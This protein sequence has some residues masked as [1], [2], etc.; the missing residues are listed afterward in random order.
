MKPSANQSTPQSIAIGVGA[1]LIAGLTFSLSFAL[2]K[3]L[4]PEIPTAQI[5][6][7]RMSVGLLLLM[8]L[9]LR[10]PPG[11]L[12]TTRPGAHL[13]R[14]A[15]GATSMAMVYWAVPR[16]PLADLA[17]TQFV[18]PLFLTL[19]SAPLLG[20]M[21][22]WRRATATVVGFSG[23]I[24]MLKPTGAGFATLEPA[25]LVA[26]GSAF[27]YALAAIAMRQLGRTEPAL[28]TTIYFSAVAAMAGAI[29]CLFDWVDPTPRQWLLLISMGLVGGCGQYALVTAYARAPATIVAPF[30]YTQLIWAAVLGYVFWAEAPE[31]RGY[32]GAAI[33][34]GAGMYI[35]HREAIRQRVASPPRPLP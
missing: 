1:A 13:K 34:A 31:T 4:G 26:L 7:F 15:V 17:A 23:V 22:G 24:V 21:V 2:I 20:E 18:M 32:L 14:I 29:G 35:F 27:F 5:M 16:M 3:A 9:L 10:A 6:L 30:D 33:V 25:Y 8:P 12:R 19:L 11:I 28:R